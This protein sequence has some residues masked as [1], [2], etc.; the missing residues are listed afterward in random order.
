VVWQLTNRTRVSGTQQNIHL[1]TVPRP[2]NVNI[3]IFGLSS[4]PA[5]RIFIL[6][7]TVLGMGSWMSWFQ[8]QTLPTAPAV[9]WQR[10]RF[11][12]WVAFTEGDSAIIENAYQA[13]HAEYPGGPP[14]K[15]G[16][17]LNVSSVPRSKNLEYFD[18]HVYTPSNPRLIA[19]T[20][21]RR[22]GITI[23]STDYYLLHPT[24]ATD[25]LIATTD[26]ATVPKDGE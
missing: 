10:G 4:N 2:Q 26:V 1:P 7:R 13:Y 8:S 18:T 23:S 20:P 9:V 6:I 16:I 15:V 3:L 19:V 12:K 21:L 25:D 22:I 5:L 14:P 11:Y 17:V 24:A